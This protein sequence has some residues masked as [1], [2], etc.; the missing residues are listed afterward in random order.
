MM[1]RRPR[2][3][4][5]WSGDSSDTCKGDTYHRKR[6]IKSAALPKSYHVFFFVTG[7]AEACTTYGSKGFYK[8]LQ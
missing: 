6:Q 8:N 2:D 5:S 4:R 1:E 3:S 7:G